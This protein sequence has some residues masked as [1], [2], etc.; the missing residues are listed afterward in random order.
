MVVL[1]RAE[2]GSTATFHDKAGEVVASLSWPALIAPPKVAEE[3]RSH[4][5]AVTPWEKH[6]PGL[7]SAGVEIWHTRMLGDV[8][9]WQK[10]SGQKEWPISPEMEA[11][12]K[13]SIRLSEEQGL[14]ERLEAR[15]RERPRQLEPMVPYPVKQRP[16]KW[17]G[18]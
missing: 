4:G 12:I 1:Q 18:V 8:G 13:E 2:T 14:R 9:G 5:Y 11:R 7:Y 17:G 6:E 15:A 3:I 16:P 10:D